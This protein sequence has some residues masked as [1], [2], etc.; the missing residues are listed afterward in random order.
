MNSKQQDIWLKAAVIGSIWAS[1][2][3]VFGSFFHSLRLPFA[4]T[5]L[6][7]SS[8]VLLV[9]FSYKWNDKNLF[10]K[11]GIIA[12][13]MRSLMPTSVILGPLIGILIEAVLFQLSINLLGRNFTGFA[14]A[15]VLA[16]FSAIIHKIVSIILIYGF[17]IV[18]ILENLYYVLLRSTHLD[19]PL[20]QLLILVAVVYTLAGITVALLGMKLGK[21]A[22]ASTVDAV[23]IGEKW[24]VKNDLFNIDAR[25][26]YRPQLIFLHLLVLIVLLVALEVFPL[27]Y[28][29]LPVLL[30]GAFI[31][32]RYGKSLRRLAK[33]LFWL[34][35]AVIVLI[36]VWL[37]PDKTEGFMMGMKMI[38][39]AILVVAIFTAISVELKNPLVKALLY[40]RG[41]SQLYA[42]LGMATSAVP[43]ILKNI[44]EE[45]KTLLNPLKVLEKAIA[46]S[47]VLLDE[48]SEQ[49][50]QK[51]KILIISGD[52]RSGKT[53]FLKQVIKNLKEQNP[54][55][56][57]GGIIAT[58]IDKDGE[59]YGF[60][61]EELS[62]GQKN[63]LCTREPQENT[64]KIGRFY[65]YQQ[66]LDT[67][68]RLIVESLP[69][70]D[71]L[72]IDEVGY[73]ELKGRGWFEVIEEAMK[74][75]D[76]NMIF[77][78]RKRLLE[79]VLNLWQDYYIEV[80][81]V[82]KTRIDEVIKIL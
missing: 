13:L 11:A 21:K 4:G 9:A 46:L 64:E 10:L 51:N 44:S 72:V 81:D 41:Y 40:R 79:D 47:D 30:Y 76:L 17:D 74:Q 66:V 48:F 36:A 54:D 50:R 19:L 14:V 73:L 45:K 62:T 67:T 80:F 52:T 12:A 34:Q 23:S 3:I 75:H 70:L 33:P 63:L 15:G 77:V 82:D 58:G 57:I 69:A 32:K 25:F 16:M 2:E 37:W 65:F 22:L 42:T 5:F 1:F 78:V 55:F 35:L 60:E 24:T 53:T 38:L 26:H 6:T 68:R 8:I 59:R 7:F 49:M 27:Y 43:F 39:R 71:L 20:N 28:S 56:S 61:I 29:L 31:I 18:K